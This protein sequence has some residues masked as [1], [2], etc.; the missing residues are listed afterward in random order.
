MEPDV[1]APEGEESFATW[2]KNEYPAL[3]RLLTL[4]IGDAEEAIE[5]TS[6]A[7]AIALRRWDHVSQMASPTGWAYTVALNIARTSFRRL[8]IES[9]MW[10]RRSAP[11]PVHS[12]DL[13]VW[14]A[15]QRLPLRQRTAVALHYLSDLP[16]RDVAAAMG[17]T[18][19]TVAATLHEA[20]RRL[21]I[22][23]GQPIRRDATDHG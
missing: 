16:Q 8:R 14:D 12:D 13:E 6:E 17:V 3:V 7:F 1:S 22:A 23:L 18:E 9:L 21:A 4:V 11:P 15:V 19:G 10:L 2:Y 5:A 20:R